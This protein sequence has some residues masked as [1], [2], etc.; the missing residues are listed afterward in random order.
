LA[1]ISPLHNYWSHVWAIPCNAVPECGDGRDEMNCQMS[2]WVLEIVLV[3]I[4]C[5]LCIT[6][7]IYLSYYLE[8]TIID[9]SIV[10]IPS[11]EQNLAKRIRDIVILVEEGNIDK[12]REFYDKE[13]EMHGNEAN[14][15]CCLKVDYYLINKR[16]EG[17]I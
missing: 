5:I 8:H 17:K 9:K 14:A 7:F 11:S 2:D 3:G 4:I 16:H 13:V 6:L 10:L 15:I 12:I 1:P